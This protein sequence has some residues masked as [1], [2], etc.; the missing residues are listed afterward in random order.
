MAPQLFPLECSIILENLNQSIFQLIGRRKAAQVDGFQVS[1][2]DANCNWRLA[3]ERTHFQKIYNKNHITL[4]IYEEYITQVWFSEKVYQRRPKLPSK[5]KMWGTF[6]LNF[7]PQ[8]CEC[9]KRNDVRSCHV[10]WVIRKQQHVVINPDV[11]LHR[12]TER[13]SA[14]VSAL[15]GG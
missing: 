7:F 5:M 9:C 13:S 2:I 3:F 11:K 4:L 12:G 15:T 14:L 1:N 8:E 10:L 6:W